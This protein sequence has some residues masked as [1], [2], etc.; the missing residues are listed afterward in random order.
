MSNLSYDQNEL[1]ILPY[2][3]DLLDDKTIF[4]SLNKYDVFDYYNTA[5]KKINCELKSRNIY[6]DSYPTSMIGLN[7]I[8]ACNNPDVD[9]YFFFHFKNN[10]VKY[11]KYNKDV[12]KEFEIKLSGRKDRGRIEE[13][14]YIYVPI[15]KCETLMLH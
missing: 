6:Y 10:V 3:Q 13:S 9:Y 2:I 5:H 1:M 7:K 12:F 8:K 14:L 4:K 11:I 15:N